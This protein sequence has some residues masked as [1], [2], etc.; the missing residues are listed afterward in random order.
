MQAKQFVASCCFSELH[1]LLGGNAEV[2]LCSLSIASE[3]LM[4]L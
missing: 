4:K 2:P 1:E 3:M